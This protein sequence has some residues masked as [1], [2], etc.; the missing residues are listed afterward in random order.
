MTAGRIILTYNG[1]NSSIL[2][3]NPTINFWKSSYSRYTN[4]S[5][6]SIELEC[7]DKI[8]PDE[9]NSTTYR[10]QVHRYADLINYMHLT[11][12]LPAIYS[13]KEEFVWIKHLGCSI[14]NYARLYINDS[15]IEEIDGRYL[16]IYNSL[17]NDTYKSDYFNK[18][19]GN[20]PEM[21]KPYI[22]NRDI[23]H[24]NTPYTSQ[25]NIDNVIFINRNYNSQASIDSY[26]LNIPL[27]F[28][29]FRNNNN[30]PLVSLSKS[31]VFIEVNLK[32]IRDLYTILKVENIEVNKPVPTLREYWLY[33]TLKDESRKID[34][35]I[36]KRCKDTNNFTRFTKSTFSYNSLKPTINANYVFLDNKERTLFATLDIQN[37]TIFNDHLKYYNLNG[38]VHLDSKLFH[39]VKNFIIMAQR[40]DVSERNEWM[41]FTNFDTIDHNPFYFQ[42][43]YLDYSKKES[44][45]TSDN[46]F[47]Y[48]YQFTSLVLPDDNDV[49]ESIE[50]SLLTKENIKTNFYDNGL[51]ENVVINNPGD[52]YSKY[53]TI[54]I[55]NVSAIDFSAS[56]KF[57]ISYPIV[58]EKGTY[59]NIPNYKITPTN[60]QD[61]ELDISIFDSGGLKCVDVI[62]GGTNYDNIINIEILDTFSISD[63][64]IY[65]E[66]E[67]Y[68][69]DPQ[70][71][72]IPFPINNNSRDN[73]MNLN[74]SDAIIKPI[75]SKNQVVE[76]II[77]NIGSGYDKNICE[78]K[79]YIGGNLDSSLPITYN[80]SDYV[81]N[82]I[83][84]I[85]FFD[86]VNQIIVPKI[87]TSV[88]GGLLS[89]S[90]SNNSYINDGN[91]GTN[92]GRNGLSKNTM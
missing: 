25:S 71:N 48:L 60:G 7:E 27:I 49:S 4:F 20:I 68:T 2:N 24:T 22:N 52:Y 88:F 6:Q 76:L 80:Y 63:T 58:K 79:I 9:I 64:K 72:V 57:G 34:L 41:N 39:P 10:F 42:N 92:V 28:G 54:N 87:N 91:Y 77:D 51:V 81:F 44:N 1:K 21:N 67:E 59:K 13:D 23:N 35:E 56:A 75:V 66:G 50:Q 83:P 5:M 46:I 33:D 55:D 14:L 29:C 69:S 86:N 85:Y 37:L 17:Y 61:I 47:K 3:G 36:K 74:I 11:I 16:Y 78:P 89:F 40:T 70:I 31:E 90:I 15:L 53:P 32:G 65:N 45:Y 38:L 19:T 12:N 26:Q 82:E 30:L 43:K 18:L 73:I 62:N 8:I 84:D